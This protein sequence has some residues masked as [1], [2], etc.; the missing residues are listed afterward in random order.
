[1]T[2]TWLHSQVRLLGGNFD[3]HLFRLVTGYDFSPWISVN[4][5]VQYDNVTKFLGTNNRFTWVINP[6]NTFFVVYNHN[7]QRYDERLFSMES[8]TNIKFAYTFRF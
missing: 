3:T 7:W 5:N 8:R 6:G 1:M 4:F 2:A